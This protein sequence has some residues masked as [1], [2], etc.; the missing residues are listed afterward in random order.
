M[1][2]PLLFFLRYGGKLLLTSVQI[3][4]CNFIIEPYLKDPVH[5]KY[6]DATV[7]EKYWDVGGVRY[8]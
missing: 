2:V 4:F 8:V 5:S 6:I 7:L 1:Y 3:Y